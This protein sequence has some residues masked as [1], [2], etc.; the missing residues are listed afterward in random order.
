MAR[1][2]ASH[3]PAPGRGVSGGRGHHEAPTHENPFVTH[4][5]AEYV[6]TTLT[7]GRVHPALAQLP[8][9]DG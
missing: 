5:V 7:P 2:G 8:A 9:E 4:G 6:M 3:C 1:R